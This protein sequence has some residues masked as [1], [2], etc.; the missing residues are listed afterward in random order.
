MDSIKFIALVP[1]IVIVHPQT[2]C[3]EWPG[4]L[5]EG[6]GRVY[7]EGKQIEAHRASYISYR[8]PIPKGLQI[9]HL[10]RNRSCINPDHLEKVTKKENCLRG[11][12]PSAVNSRKIQCI[13]GHEFVE[14]GGR[15]T[16]YQCLKEKYHRTKHLRKKPILVTRLKLP[17]Q[18]NSLV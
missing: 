6:Y 11:T 12:S 8:G 1:Q 15:R 5:K 4:H 13:R 17:H 16:C 2:Q 3:W 10:C 9:D 14:R 18:P 7:F